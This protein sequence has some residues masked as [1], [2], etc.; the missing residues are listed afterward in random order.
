M[1]GPNVQVFGTPDSQP[2]R[3]ALRFFKERRID[4]HFIDIRRKP[5]AP[6]EFRRFVDKLGAPAL[7]D[8]DSKAWRDAGLAHLRMDPA[9]LADRLFAEQRFLKLPLV[10]VNSEV[11]AGPD[12]LGWK[13][14]LALV[15]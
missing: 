13:R 14:M 2:T 4:V 11:A 10:R 5:L 7:A 9:E 15:S 3:A 12:E 6:A 8:T 1:S